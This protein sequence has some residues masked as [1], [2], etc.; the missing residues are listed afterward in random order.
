VKLR[1]TEPQKIKRLA[2]F[3]L[4]YTE[5]PRDQRPSR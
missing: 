1:L 3:R 2:A 4:E 5:T